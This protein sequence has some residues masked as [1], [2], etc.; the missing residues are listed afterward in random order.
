[1]VVSCCVVYYVRICILC[2]SVNGGDSEVN[3]KMQFPVEINN[4][5]ISF[6]AD[7]RSSSIVIAVK[8]KTLHRVRISFPSRTFTRVVVAV[9]LVLLIVTPLGHVLLPAAVRVLLI[10]PEGDW[11]AQGSV[12]LAQIHV[13]DIHDVF[14]FI[15]VGFYFCKT[16]NN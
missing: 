5:N 3:T 1:M 13:V 7:D 10:V 11:V 9:G 8:N 2:T 15:V 12:A 16:I 6:N 4:N 14:V